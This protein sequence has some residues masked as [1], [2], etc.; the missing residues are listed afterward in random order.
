MQMEVQRRLSDQLEV[1]R[2]PSVFFL[3]FSFSYDNNVKEKN[4]DLFLVSKH[5]H[6]W[7]ET[8]IDLL[9]SFY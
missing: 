4:E 5:V 8:R 2:I 3:S 1:T 6:V 7:K 9:N